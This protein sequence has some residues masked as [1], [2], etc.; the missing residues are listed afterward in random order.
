VQ[1][2]FNLHWVLA[3]MGIVFGVIGIGVCCC[4]EWPFSELCRASTL[5]KHTT[6]WR[7]SHAQSAA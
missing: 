6:D 7:I 3:V 5:H 4:G 1:A 2:W